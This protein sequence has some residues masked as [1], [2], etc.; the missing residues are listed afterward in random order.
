MNTYI[1]YQ[2]SGKIFQA[3]ADGIQA[4]FDATRVLV[5]YWRDLDLTNA[6][7][8][9]LAFMGALAGIPWPL[10]PQTYFGNVFEFDDAAAFPEFNVH[11]GFGD[12]YDPTVGGILGS[13]ELTPMPSADYRR[14]IPLAAQLKYYGLTI[15]TVDLIASWTGVGYTIGFDADNDILLAFATRITTVQI[16]ILEL[17]FGMYESC[18]RVVIVN[19]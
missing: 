5:E 17:L 3:V 15:Y 12:V 14:L 11:K 8:F 1:S 7:D 19:P 2:F 9:E 18:P 4:S 16:F 13:G 6:Q 10:V